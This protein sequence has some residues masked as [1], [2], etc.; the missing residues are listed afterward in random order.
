MSVSH[1]YKLCCKDLEVK[2]IY[3]GSTGDFRRRQWE[4]KSRCTCESGV[5][6]NFK[7]YQYIRINGGWKNWEMIEL[8]RCLDIDK[9]ELHQRERYWIESLNSTLNCTIPTRPRCESWKI[10]YEKYKEI[11]SEK[12]K[13]YHQ[14]NRESVLKKQK[15]Y[16]ENNRELIKMRYHD[17][18]ESNREKGRLK[19]IK[20][21][22]KINKKVLCLCGIYSTKNH[23]NRHRRSETC[24]AY[25]AQLTT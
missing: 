9:V 8:E 6:Y 10:Y 19:Y 14:K 2:E 16:R 22:E 25:H 5:Y 11:L 15:I 17:N 21:R 20:N 4:H 7:V 12:G 13:L 23:M 24:L 1:V 3:V 18:I